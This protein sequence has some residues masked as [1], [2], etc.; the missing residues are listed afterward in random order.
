MSNKK[1]EMTEQEEQDL[2][3]NPINDFCCSVCKGSEPM[4]FE[5]FKKHIIR[6]HGLNDGQ[7]KGTKSM[8]MHMDGTKWFSSTYL[9]T[10]ESG[11]KFTQHIRLA[12][13]KDDMMRFSQ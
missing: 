5:E 13:A 3:D 1:D 7:L 6:V 12:R 11:L 9:W 8:M 4:P 2:I 10:L